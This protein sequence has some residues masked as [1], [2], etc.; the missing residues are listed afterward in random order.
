[1]TTEQKAALKFGT[2]LAGK[3]GL[4]SRLANRLVKPV[5]KSG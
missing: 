5:L 2:K 4:K 1:L 3:A